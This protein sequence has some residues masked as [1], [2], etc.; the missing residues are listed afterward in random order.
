[1]RR[2]LHVAVGLGLG[3]V[4]TG[5]I[6]GGDFGRPY[7]ASVDETRPLA[8]TGELSLENTNGSVHLVAWDEAKVRVEAVKRARSERALEELK[9]EIEAEGDRVSVRTRYPRPH[10]MGGAGSVEYRVSVPRGA[11]VRVGTVNGRVEVRDVSGIV[12][13]ST[14]NGS[15]EV[16]GAGSAV[17][18]SAVN[19][20]VEVD[21]ARVD[22]SGRS[23]LSTTN[24]SVTL[25]LPR[26]ANAD[27]EAHTV[28]GS[29]RCDFDLADAR[30]SRRKIQGRI[31]S[32]GAR[33]EIGTVNGSAHIDRGLSA[34]ASQPPAEAP[35]AG[36]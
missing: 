34:P 9:V 19:G 11:R 13:A 35:A 26:D 17:E 10:W 27:V 22:P 30:Q 24:G 28:N 8:A 7:R 2:A 23:D 1:M 5:C 16:T 15:V 14:V 6:G 20:G 32:G 29:V 18:A 25:T 33:F 3:L 31:G 36:R 12:R 21:V 4:L